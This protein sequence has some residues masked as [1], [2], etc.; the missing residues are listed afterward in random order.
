MLKQLKVMNEVKAKKKNI[1]HSLR[2]LNRKAN[3]Y[4]KPYSITR[5]IYARGYRS[6]LTTDIWKEAKF[7]LLEYKILNA[8][9]LECPICHQIVDKNHSVLHHKKYNRRKLFKPNYTTFVHYKCHEHIHQTKKFH[10]IPKCVK[11]QLL[12]YSLIFLSLII[13]FLFY[14]FY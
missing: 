6:L 3:K 2:T 1:R 12:F 10:L 5:E 7:L 13:V 14:R 9:Y 11:R 8:S 4:M